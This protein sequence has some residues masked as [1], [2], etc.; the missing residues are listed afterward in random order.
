M[1]ALSTMKHADGCQVVRESGIAVWMCIGTCP[2]VAAF[3]A[4]GQADQSLD[5]LDPAQIETVIGAVT[6][7]VL[8]GVDARAA[9]RNAKP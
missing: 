1:S 5:Q 9:E 3:I 8:A 7:H 6:D 4:S 2:A